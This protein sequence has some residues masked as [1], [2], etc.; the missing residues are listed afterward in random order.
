MWK[1]YT[2][3]YFIVETNIHVLFRAFDALYHLSFLLEIYIHTYIFFTFCNF[4]KT[5]S[6]YN[7]YKKT[8]FLYFG[9]IEE[10]GSR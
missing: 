8:N 5:Y 4:Y 10:Y 1:C 7:S 9:Y 2:F 3:N 6:N